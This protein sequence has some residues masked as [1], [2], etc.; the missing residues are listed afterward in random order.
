MLREAPS[1]D[2]WQSGHQ[3]VAQRVRA[4]LRAAEVVKLAEVFDADGD[5]GNRAYFATNCSN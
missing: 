4:L 5:I 3:C 1:K 2:S